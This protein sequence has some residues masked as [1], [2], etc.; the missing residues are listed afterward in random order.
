M[1]HRR[2]P[3]DQGNVKERNHQVALMGQIY[4]NATEVVIWL[5]SGT[6]ESDTVMDHL[7]VNVHTPEKLSYVYSHEF[8]SHPYWKSLWVQ[9][10]L[11]LAKQLEIFYGNKSLDSDTV[12]L[13][14]SACSNSDDYGAD[15]PP[16]EHMTC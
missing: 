8:A 15:L 3:I 14:I 4:R 10:E 1:R 16:S 12:D 6:E 9:Q 13:L 2:N 5:G 7:Q 11:I